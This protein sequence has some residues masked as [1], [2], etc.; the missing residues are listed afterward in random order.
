MTSIFIALI[1]LAVPKVFAPA[2]ARTTAGS[3]HNASNVQIATTTTAVKLAAPKARSGYVL[4]K[5]V[6]D[7][8]TIQLDSGQKVRYIGVN[9][10][11]SVDPRKAVQCFGKEAS[12]KNAELVAGKLVRLVKDV[13]NT[14]KYGRL[15]RYVYLEDGTFVN[16]SLVR[17]GYAEVMTIPPNVAKSKL[18]RDAAKEAR[19]AKLGLWS[20]CK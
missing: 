9:T 11:E 18:F 10:P 17:E 12:K 2:S 3:A 1:G 6:V 13:S 20:A 8:D 19:A 4:V 16:E 15:L 5:R 14:D 7:G